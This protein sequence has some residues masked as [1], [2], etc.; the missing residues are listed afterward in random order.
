MLKELKFLKL[1]LL[2]LVTGPTLFINEIEDA[3]ECWLPSSLS[4]YSDSLRAQEW[5][6]DSSA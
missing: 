2:A 4:R 3:R 5:H 6:L 1:K